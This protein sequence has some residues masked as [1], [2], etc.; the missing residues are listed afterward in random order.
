MTPWLVDT[1]VLTILARYLYR[2]PSAWA[3]PTGDVVPIH[4]SEWV[5]FEARGKPSPGAPPSPESDA[6]LRRTACCTIHPVM[7]PSPTWDVVERLTPHGSINR[8][9]AELIA[10]AATT[11]PAGCLVTLDEKASYT[12][13]VELGPGRV[14]SPFDFFHALIHEHGLHPDAWP[15]LC[16]FV[17]G[18]TIPL[19]LA[20]PPA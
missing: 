7:V 19:R 2:F 18:Y 1:G 20:P 10:L 9:E 11:V 3:H 13:L 5:A 6:L 16:R 12:A 14:A 17:Q 15:A 8:G 4:V